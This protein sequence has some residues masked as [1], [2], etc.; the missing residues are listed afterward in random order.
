M[1]ALMINENKF[2]HD[3]IE[4]DDLSTS[5]GGSDNE[6]SPTS[7]DEPPSP[8]SGALVAPL[9]SDL[10]KNAVFAAQ[11]HLILSSLLEVCVFLSTV[12]FGVAMKT[13]LPAKAPISR[14]HTSTLPPRP[15][16]QSRKAAL[17]SATQRRQ[18][19]PPPGLSLPHH[20]TKGESFT[21]QAVRPPPGLSLQHCETQDQHLSIE[22]I[23]PPPGLSLQREAECHHVPVPAA[24]PPPGLEAFSPPPGIFFAQSQ[25]D[26]STKPS[27]IV[28]SQHT[29][30][31]KRIN[32]LGGSTQ[33]VAAESPK[34]PPSP[35]PVVPR[36]FE[37][38]VYRKELSDVLRDLATRNNVA[39]SV[40]RIRAQNVP[41]ERQ[42][43]EFRDILT[44]AAEETRGVA[45]RLSFAFAAGLAAGAP[46]SA[47]AREEC[48]SGIQL[49]F[50]DVFEDLASEVPR[51]RNKLANELV[52]TLCT[53]FSE[54]EIARL[55]PADCRTVVC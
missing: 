32:A 45:R 43:P 35:S 27:N 7:E 16:L 50:D 22:E 54:D 41:R 46:D 6:V 29:R 17:S 42:A 52:P 20:K 31:R 21:N 44:R 15:Q 2:M 28:A 51:L 33:P 47:F 19:R 25:K 40:K 53:V 39:A 24:R 30:G 23:G 3:S 34:L 8:T 14:T 12:L 18:V 36:E 1:S 4:K 13:K 10:G 26:A 49:F 38:A 9:A 55:L 11:V 5:A 48:L 37:Q